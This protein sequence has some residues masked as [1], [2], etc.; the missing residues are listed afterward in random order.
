MLWDSDF[1]KKA[2][3]DGYSLPLGVEEVIS[4][5]R[6]RWKA[7]YDLQLV[8][9]KKRL[10][11]HLMWAYLE[12]QSFPMDEE[13]YKTHLNEVLEVVNRLGLAAEVRE[14]LF[15]SKKKPRLGKAVS[16]ELKADEGLEEFVL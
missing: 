15:T 2:E 10:Y 14:W 6:N 5:L 9:R 13:T 7:T 1:V 8:V 16:F 3:F 11:L 4:C 12:Q